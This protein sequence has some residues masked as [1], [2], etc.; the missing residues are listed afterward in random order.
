MPKKKKEVVTEEIVADI[1]E[2]ATRNRLTDLGHI[3]KG[4]KVNGVFT[5]SKNGLSHEVITFYSGQRLITVS[6]APLEP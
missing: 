4:D 3:E 5:F 6:N 1:L 2:P